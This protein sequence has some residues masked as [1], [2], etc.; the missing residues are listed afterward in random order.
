CPG[1]R[2]TTVVT[3]MGVFRKDVGGDEL[4]LTACLPDDGLPNPGDRIKRI[5]GNCGWTLKTADTVE[6][7]AEPSP[8][9]LR[10]LRR[11]VPARK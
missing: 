1:K 9:E 4:R 7:I 8:D 10:L 2:V 5:Q 6:E 3:N 11:L